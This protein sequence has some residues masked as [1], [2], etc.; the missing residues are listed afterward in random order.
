MDLR[1]E[2]AGQVWD[3]Y[4]AA[5]DQHPATGLNL[6]NECCDRWARGSERVAL[7]VRHADGSSD[8]HT[9]RD[10]MRASERAANVFAQAGLKRGDRLAAVLSRQVEAWIAALA[11]WRSG[12][13]YVP[14]F[15][16]FGADALAQRLKAAHADAVV[17][18]H[19]WRDTLE[20]ARGR[21]DAD[22]DVF[23]VAGAGGAGI[24][25]GDR[26]F[27][28]DMDQAPDRH[29]IAQTAAH[30]PAVLMFTSG[31]TSVPK[32][33]VIPHQGIVSLLPW[34]DLSCGLTERDVLFTTT[35]PGW[36]FGL[37]STGAAPMTAG[38]TRVMYTGDFDARA[39]LDVIEAERVTHIAAV[40]TAF[41]RLVAEGLRSGF[42]SCLRG[43][44]SAGEPL[45]EVAVT[46]WQELTDAPIRD[47]YGQ[48]ELGMVIANLDDGRAVV[49]G[50]LASVVP[51]WNVRLIDDERRTVRG[52]GQGMIAVERPPF[53]LTSTYVNAQDLW[54]ARWFDGDWFLTGDIARRDEDGRYWFVGR[55]DDVIVTAGY[56]VGPAEVE[57]VLMTHPAVAEAAVVAAPDLRRGGDAVRAVLVLAPGNSASPE[58]TEELKKLV[59]EGIGRHAYPR[60]VEYVDAL[61]KTETGKIRRAAI[62]ARA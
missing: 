45:D 4:V 58:L 52:P 32:G 5:L 47:G 62:R 41:R 40:P 24:R 18:G 15:C 30:E 54:D 28:A 51:G 8:R 56:N 19:P 55:D 39:W 49:P 38:I 10:L 17:V 53:Q 37:L 12:L 6:A 48:T 35:D 16:G 2:S 36:S 59:R 11:A 33:C 3:R 42:P 43:A 14:L 22:L 23:T 50:A 34:M 9:Y 31:T 26:S 60:L 25:D 44:T 20:A 61:P 29:Q 57:S 13:L 1:E 27:W 7:I 21:L 46:G